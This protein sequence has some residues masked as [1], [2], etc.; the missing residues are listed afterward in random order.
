MEHCNSL[1][2]Y[3]YNVS[4]NNNNSTTTIFTFAVGNRCSNCSNRSVVYVKLRYAII[5][6]SNTEHINYETA[7]NDDA[8]VGLLPAISDAN[9]THHLDRDANSVAKANTHHYCS[10]NTIAYAFADSFANSCSDSC[11]DSKADSGSNTA[12]HNDCATADTTTANNDDS[13]RNYGDDRDRRHHQRRA[14]CTDD[15]GQLG[16]AGH[17]GATPTSRAFHCVATPTSS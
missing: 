14:D 8:H 2:Y 16:R 7:D 12:T 1:S 17:S 5:S 13:N 11:S 4:N 15:D 10:T 3:H 6:F 9:A